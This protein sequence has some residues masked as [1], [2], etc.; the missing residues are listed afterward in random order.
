MYE[1]GKDSRKLIRSRLAEIQKQRVELQKQK[2]QRLQESERKRLRNAENMTNLV[3][4][5]SLC[6]NA[7]QIE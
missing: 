6:K 4:Y 3:C 1:G 2:Q 7:N 5:Y